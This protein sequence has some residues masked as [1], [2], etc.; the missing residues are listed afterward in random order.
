MDRTVA[1]TRGVIIGFSQNWCRLKCPEEM[2][3]F[4]IFFSKHFNRHQFYENPMITPRVIATVRSIKLRTVP[5][6]S[7]LVYIHK[8][9][10]IGTS[11]Q[12]Q[13]LLKPQYKNA[14][15]TPRLDLK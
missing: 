4:G 6:S 9:P 3:L 7:R 11:A 13:L 12:A 5:S 1:I 10:V 2:G 15:K 8:Q 14:S